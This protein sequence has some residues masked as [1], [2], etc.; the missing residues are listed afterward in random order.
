MIKGDFL[1]WRIHIT[2][3]LFVLILCLFIRFY[4]QDVDGAKFFVS[5]AYLVLY[6][7]LFLLLPI[8]TRY[9]S[10]FQFLL[11]PSV[12]ILLIL[13]LGLNANFLAQSRDRIVPKIELHDNNQLFQLI[14]GAHYIV[15]KEIV[16]AIKV[17]LDPSLYI[18]LLNST[19]SVNTN[20][21]G[22]ISPSEFLKFKEHPSAKLYLNPQM[23][24]YWYFITEESSVGDFQ[25]RP[26]VFYTLKIA[27]SLFDRLPTLLAVE[28]SIWIEYAAK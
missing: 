26:R 14:D 2:L 24:G 23:F 4:P 5:D 10:K 28:D 25:K 20:L 27:P 6:S 19:M 18:R 16:D 9:F 1:P 12:P 22:V 13:G 3:L 8:A 17:D 11:A 15:P 21:S 7:V